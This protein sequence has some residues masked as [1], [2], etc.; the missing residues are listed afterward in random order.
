MGFP[1]SLKMHHAGDRVSVYSFQK[2]I[3]ECP[4]IERFWSKNEVS[5][6]PDREN[7]EIRLYYDVADDHNFSHRNCFSGRFRWFRD[8]ATP[9]PTNWDKPG[10]EALWALIPQKDLKNLTPPYPSLRLY[11]FRIEKVLIVGNGGVKDVGRTHE[12]REL[13]AA[14]RDVQYVLD[15]VY[16]RITFDRT[17]SIV[18][19][20]E[21]EDCLLDGDL[22]FDLSA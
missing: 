20:G 15:R 11:C 17:L 18:N 3:H 21:L 4:E 9:G 2:D 10:V 16:D 14:Q 13:L 19:D 12:S 22:E 6:A 7:L 8:E 5:T 1:F